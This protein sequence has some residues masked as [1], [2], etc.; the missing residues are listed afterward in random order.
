[1]LCRPNYSQC[2]KIHNMKTVKFKTLKEFL[3]HTPFE[4]YSLYHFAVRCAE[5]NGKGYCRIELPRSVEDEL[6]KG[7]CSVVFASRHDER[8]LWRIRSTEQFG[9]LRNVAVLLVKGKIKFQFYGNFDCE[10]EM[11]TI[12]RNL[13]GRQASKREL[14]LYALHKIYVIEA[15]FDYFFRV[16]RRL[17]KK[18]E[19]WANDY[20]KIPNFKKPDFE[21]AIQRIASMLKNKEKFREDFLGDYDPRGYSLKLNIPNASPDLQIN[22]GGDVII[23]PDKL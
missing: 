17:E 19:K 14:H 7:F 11:R 16:C 23:A 10:S 13:V 8:K 9:L 4:Q 21:P 2:K 5:I 15:N 1:M 12:Q 6:V 18:Y 3:R 22:L 20:S